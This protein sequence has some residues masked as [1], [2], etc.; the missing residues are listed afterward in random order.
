MS[1]I[2]PRPSFPEALRFW[3]RLGLIS[4]GGPAGQIAIMH[5]ELVDKRR[6]VSEAQFLHG[7][8]YCMLLPGPEAQQLA[9]YLGWLMHRT[10]GGI[11]AGA[12]FVLPSALILWVLSWL[13]VSHGS[14]P[15][16]AGVF[17]GLKP[18]VLAIVL[19]AVLRI[20]QRVLKTSALWIV[21]SVALAAIAWLHV[22]FPF[23][24]IGAALI[25]WFGGKACP[26]WFKA[27]LGHGSKATTRAEASRPTGGWMRAVRV[28]SVCVI[29]WAAPVLV[30]LG[31][32][33]SGHVLVKQG[34]F[35]SKAAMVT[36]G[37]AYAVL[38]YV[39]QRAVEVYGWVTPGEMLDGLGLAETTPGPLIMVLQFVGF[40]GGWKAAAP[41]SPWLGA[42]LAAAITTWTTFLP[43]FLWI[44]L[45]APHIERLGENRRLNA[46]LSTITAAIAGVMLNLALW[47]GGHVLWPEGKAVNG[48]GIAIA[49]LAFVALQR[50]KVNLIAIIAAAAVAGGLA[51]CLG[52]V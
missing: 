19:A 9:T 23:I 26:D 36:F 29:L 6:W 28:T 37:G 52:I 32:L 12:L 4:F 45:S 46:V 47:F 7:L 2:A 33:G 21:A 15:S 25:G 35:F 43:S 3:M 39:S 44:F 48:F 40:L 38:P 17:V 8:N 50:Y 1:D 42:T 20:G 31:W 27:S 22:P 18:A 14:M 13:Y 30:A 41:F 49:A 5:T 24:V 34:V 11:A 51:A 10:K 16:V